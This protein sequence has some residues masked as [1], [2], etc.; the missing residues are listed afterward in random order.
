M[1]GKLS[2]GETPPSTT[3]ESDSGSDY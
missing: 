3:D 2:V 1:T